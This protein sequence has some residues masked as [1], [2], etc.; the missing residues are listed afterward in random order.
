VTSEQAATTVT[1]AMTVAGAA[2]SQASEAP[3]R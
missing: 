1:A 3:Q 2:A